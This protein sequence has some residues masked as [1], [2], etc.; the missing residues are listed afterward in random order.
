[1]AI[2]FNTHQSHPLIEREQT[3][4]LEKSYITIHSEDRDIYKWKDSNNFEIRLPG[5]LNNVINLRLSDINI[6][7]NIYT[8][9]EG[10]QNTK[11]RFTV[12]PQ[13]NTT[14]AD[15]SLEFHALQNYNISFDY[16]EAT[17]NE[18]QYTQ[19]QLAFEIQNVMN[20]TITQTLKDLETTDPSFAL[21]GDCYHYDDFVVKYNPAS[22][23]ME[24]INSRD[25]F[26]LLFNEE[27]IYPNICGAI[28]KWDQLIDWGFPYY[29]GY[30]KKKYVSF[31]QQSVYYV[32]SIDYKICASTVKSDD[33]VYY[34]VSP[35][36]VD[37]YGNNTIYMEVDKY[38][39]TDEINPHIY[40]FNSLHGDDYAGKVDSVF[41]KINLLG[42]Q[43]ENTVLS[44]KED[45]NLVT[46][47]KV[48][49]NKITRLRFKFRHHDGTLVDFQN[50]KFN[51]TIEATHLIDEQ[52]KMKII[53]NIHPE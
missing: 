32:N 10:R 11:F 27:I 19:E 23:K 28:Y 20:N 16:Y 13:L 31:F 7:N 40:A 38:N 33:K 46:T 30:E 29:I 17:I 9:T 18:G 39:N 48:P 26:E 1:M 24:I 37:L 25:S 44:K 21:P 45:L 2:N 49:I 52:L 14:D 34:S 12:I 41:A 4:F 36:Q 51:F 6:P 8:F 42:K 47:F 15:S 5:E 3:Y 50:K 35:K 43:T 22:N 53:N